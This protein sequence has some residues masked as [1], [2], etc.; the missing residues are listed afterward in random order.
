MQTTVNSL[1]SQLKTPIWA[2]DAPQILQELERVLRHYEHL[3]YVE[4]RSEISDY[5][6]DMLYKGLERMEDEFPQFKSATSPTV[7]VGSDLLDD[8]QA[9]TH[10]AQMLSLENSYNL[11]DL[12]DF[13]RKTKERVNV[14]LDDAMEYVVEPKFD[15]G[16]I[17]LLYENDVLVRAATRGNGV[18]GDEITH[19]AKAMRTIPL[20]AVFSEYGIARVELRG[21]AIISKPTFD[22]LNEKRAAEGT[23]LLANARNAATG[24]MRVKE[25]AEVKVRGLEAFVYQLG[26]GQSILA[27]GL[28]LALLILPVVIVAT[29]EAIRAIPV[30]IREGAYALGATKWQ[31]V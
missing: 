26:F 19:N 2:A 21:E 17:V 28:A 8:F 1:L 22:K 13:D 11:E 29:R 23:A 4:S 30:T 16:T 14:P 31:T 24:V 12:Q 25:S 27:A 5:D 7:R 9:V 20:H 3:Y 6:Y 10:L 15:G 18:A